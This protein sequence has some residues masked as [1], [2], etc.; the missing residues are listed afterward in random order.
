L[1]L[2]HNQPLRHIAFRAEILISIHTTINEFSSGTEGLGH[3]GHS[4]GTATD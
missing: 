2:R 1:M 3:G 4:N